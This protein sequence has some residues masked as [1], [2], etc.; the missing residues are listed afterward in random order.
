[1]AAKKKTEEKA[2]LLAKELLATGDIKKFILGVSYWSAW[3]G[4]FGGENREQFARLLA[5]ALKGT[6]FSDAKPDV[7][8]EVGGGLVQEV[9]VSRPMTVMVCDHDIDGAE[10]GLQNI[11]E[12]EICRISTMDEVPTPYALERITAVRAT[13]K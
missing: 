2:Q 1:M 8:I 5:T 13:I 6:T 7:L 3:F 12:K 4:R 11:S 10:E 9:H